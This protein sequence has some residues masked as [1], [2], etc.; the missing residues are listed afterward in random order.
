MANKKSPKT[1][2][3]EAK[4]TVAPAAAKAAT[5][6][7]SPKAKEFETTIKIQ[8]ASKEICTCGIKKKAV[9]AYKASGKGVSGIK[10]LEIYVKPEENK[11]YYV[12]NGTE[13]GS[14]TLFDD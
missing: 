11:G 12:V 2:A 10:K 5:V 14:F 6:K 13:T 7:S 1:A 3:V 8:Y 4:K 9:E